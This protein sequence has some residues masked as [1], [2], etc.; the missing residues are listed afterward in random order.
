M[1]NICK[2]GMKN[3]WRSV[4]SVLCLF[5][6]TQRK[7]VGFYIYSIHIGKAHW[8]QRAENDGWGFKKAIGCQ[9]N[10]VSYKVS[11]RLSFAAGV[12]LAH[13]K[14]LQRFAQPPR[15][16]YLARE[17]VILLAGIHTLCSTLAI[18][19]WHSAKSGPGAFRETCRSH[20][21]VAATPLDIIGLEQNL[22]Y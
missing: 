2:R 19:D 8:F 14:I 3:I 15:Y 20:K 7:L 1:V 12:S 21:L 16:T 5:S 11:A 4:L 17:L 22:V 9:Q 10:L 6:I 18:N 13:R